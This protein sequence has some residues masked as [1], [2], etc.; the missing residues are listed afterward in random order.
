MT[1]RNEINM[2]KKDLIN[3]KNSSKSVKAAITAGLVLEVLGCCIAEN[4]GTNK[5]GEPCDVGYIKTTDGIYG[6]TSSVMINSLDD[7]A[8]YLTDAQNDGE[9]VEIRFFTGNT[10]DGTEYYNFEIM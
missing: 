6:F 4:A 2:T 1:T 3:A 5:S 7:F 9:K 10:K 8:D